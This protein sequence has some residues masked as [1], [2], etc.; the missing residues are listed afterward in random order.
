M[1]A[2]I[3]APETTT[4]ET[5][6][7]ADTSPAP[8]VRPVRRNMPSSWAIEEVT[9]TFLQDA[10]IRPESRIS[11]FRFPVG[12]T[13]HGDGFITVRPATKWLPKPNVEY[14]VNLR[15][16]KSAS[17]LVAV[18]VPDEDKGIPADEDMTS[19][20]VLPSAFQIVR[21]G[22][23]RSLIFYKPSGAICFLAEDLEEMPP[24]SSKH[25]VIMVGTESSVFRIT[26]DKRRVQGL[27]LSK[28]D[29]KEKIDWEGDITL[30][31]RP[32]HLGTLR[33]GVHDSDGRFQ[34]PDEYKLI[35]DILGI[36]RLVSNLAIIDEAKDRKLA[37][38]E[39]F[40]PSHFSPDKRPEI[41]RSHRHGL[42]LAYEA[43]VRSIETAA[44]Q[45]L[46]RHYYIERR[47][48][49]ATERAAG[50]AA[51]IAMIRQ[52][53]ASSQAHVIQNAGE[54]PKK[55]KQVSLSIVLDAWRDMVQAV[56]VKGTREE[57]HE[58]VNRLALVFGLPEEVTH[59]DAGAIQLL[60][61]EGVPA[62]DQMP[63]LK[64]IRTLQGL[65]FDY[66]LPAEEVAAEEPVNV[67]AVMEAT[68]EEVAAEHEA[69][70]ELIGSSASE[71]MGTA[72]NVVLESPNMAEQWLTV[73]EQAPGGPIGL[74]R[75]RATIASALSE[76][77]DLSPRAF[78]ELPEP[79]QVQLITAAYQTLEM[80]ASRQVANKVIRAVKALASDTTPPAG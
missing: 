3:D 64:S 29:D 78:S 54:P 52:Q 6:P 40:N 61:G 47:K 73:L 62:T 75:Q 58:L 41:S 17:F 57:L 55:R 72:E 19:R 79:T 21:R 51:R 14:T 25:P 24:T 20:E 22:R 18:P 74:A 48:R 4:V 43:R 34:R 35:E 49:L 77:T 36:S 9:L 76:T 7:A 16:N 26:Q 69:G 66:E 8:S 71:G 63:L 80:N 32:I 68:A 28:E 27:A 70:D 12:H 37:E 44:Y 38:N 50:L 31:W 5:V 23:E 42:R 53:S 45:M 33:I 56:R 15:W 39:M 10:L 1:T 67:Q 60:D 46:E 2:R 30:P 65:P 59:D 13:L 11:R